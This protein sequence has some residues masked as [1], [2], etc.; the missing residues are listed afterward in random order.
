MFENAK[1]YKKQGDIGMCY[2]MAYYSKLGWTISVPITDSQDYDF[3][4]D[5]EDELLKVQVKTTSCY[6]EYG[7]P[8]ASLKTTGGNQTCYTSKS[9]DTSKIDLLFV[10]TDKGTC[11]SIP[12]SE[13][14]AK[15]QISLGTKYQDYIVNMGV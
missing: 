13:I 15:T 9:F 12:T 5:T 8:M 3:I 6:S 10:L 14:V 4:V 1:N 11:Y 7:I 2:A